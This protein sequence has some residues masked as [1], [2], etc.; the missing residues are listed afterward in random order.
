M[1]KGES[2]LLESEDKGDYG[3]Y[4]SQLGYVVSYRERE[5]EKLYMYSIVLDYRCT[6]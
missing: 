4:R 2:V 5:R 6:H 1:A 3:A